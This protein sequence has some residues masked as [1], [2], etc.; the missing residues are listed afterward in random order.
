MKLPEV[1]KKGIL[2][3][4]W[5]LICKVYTGITG[6]PIE[7]PKPKE[8]DW[9]D[10]DID[11]SFAVPAAAD[12]LPGVRFVPGTAIKDVSDDAREQD[13]IEDDWIEDENSQFTGD[14]DGAQARREKFEATEDRDNKFVDNQGVHKKERVDI[15][16]MMGASEREPE[17]E[18]KR[19]TGLIKVQCSV[20][21]KKEETSRS[22][23]TKYKKDPDNN[24]YRCN[25][26][27]SSRGA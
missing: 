12:G 4:D 1:L 10:M 7:P 24:T 27:C 20:C 8:P 18:K 17:P 5:E 3:G 6:E 15:N 22:L 2:E 11:I 14:A 19:K 26:C 13:L 25:A 21:D 23:A 16:P 9:A